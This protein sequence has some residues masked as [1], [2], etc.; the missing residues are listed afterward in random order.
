[1]HTL[2]A[3]TAA[4]CHSPTFL[5]IHLTNMTDGVHTEPEFFK[6]SRTRGYL[7]RAHVFR[8]SLNEASIPTSMTLPRF[9]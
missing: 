2:S 6:V 7:S 4:D 1:M 5:D 9:M 8:T 3:P